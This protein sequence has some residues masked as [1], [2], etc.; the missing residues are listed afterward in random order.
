MSIKQAIRD[1]LAKGPKSL[2][3]IAH[4]LGLPIESIRNARNYLLADGVIRS[5]AGQ[6][7]GSPD[8]LYEVVP[9]RSVSHHGNVLKSPPWVPP[10]VMHRPVID[11]PGITVRRLLTGEVLT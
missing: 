3:T 11:A 1:E 5:Q 7:S 2:R 8:I 9:I 4:T 10:R 6:K